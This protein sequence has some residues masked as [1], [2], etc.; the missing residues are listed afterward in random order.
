MKLIGLEKAGYPLPNLNQDCLPDCEEVKAAIPYAEHG[1]G[2][3]LLFDAAQRLDKP[4]TF[5]GR[6]DGTCPID[7]A[8][9]RWFL[10]RQ[11]NSADVEC[12]LVPH[13]LH[14]K[15]IWWV[16]VGAYI[17]SANLTDRAWNQNHEAGVFLTQD[18]LDAQGMT[19]RLDGFFDQV[20]AQSIPLDETIY[21]AQRQLHERLKQ[22]RKDAYLVQKEFEDGHAAL[23]DRNSPIAHQPA[24]SSFTMRKRRFVAEWHE[25]LAYL[26]PLALRVAS[27]ENRPGWIREG[28]PPGVQCDQFLHAYYYTIVDPRSE[29]DAYLG[30]YERNSRHAEAAMQDALAWWKTSDFDYENERDMMER[31]APLFVEHFAEDRILALDQET[32]AET[33]AC[34]HAFGMH[35]TRKGVE[36]LGFTRSPGAWPKILAHARMI[37]DARSASGSHSGPEVFRYVIW[38]PGDVAERIWNAIHEPDYRLDGVGVSTLGEVVG[39]TRPNDFP[40]RNQRTNKAIKALGRKIKIAP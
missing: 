16:G 8:V 13:W 4:V 36:E 17:G 27:P 21:R 24:R 15:V 38:G 26:R 6:I 25:T 9:L 7:P 37:Y 30:H 19:E 34:S 22:I 2:D 5:Y 10:M 20:A 39:W 40:P 3:L 18:E 32:F 35:S 12:R 14:A 1:N 29:K 28:I 23:M 31:V 11:R 33:L